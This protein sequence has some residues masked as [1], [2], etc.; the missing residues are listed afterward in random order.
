MIASEKPLSISKQ[1]F[2]NRPTMTEKM[3]AE[4]FMTNKA[5]NG[6]LSLRSAA[7][8]AGLSLLIMAIAAPITELFLYP[9]LVVPGKPDVTVQNLLTKKP[10]FVAAVFG[11]LVTF[12]C[13]V[14]VTW[15]L[16]YLFKPVNKSLSLLTALFRLLYTAIALAALLNLVTVFQLLHTGVYTGWLAKDQLQF[17]VM[18]LLN[19]FKGQWYFGLLFFSLHLLLLGYLA[20][21]SGYVPAIVGALLILTGLG[22]LLTNLRPYLFPAVNVDF[23]RFTFYGELVFML[24]LLIRG[25]TLREPNAVSITI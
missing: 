6:E 19:A 22:Y 13:D 5:V 7:L 8:V 23:A 24:W 14:I 10:L 11:Y 15:A 2:S 3:T 17:Q 20:I 1:S 4:V 16:Y 18:L 25:R 9:K 12:I 21:R